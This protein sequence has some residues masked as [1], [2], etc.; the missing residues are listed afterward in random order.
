MMRER[1]FTLIEASITAVI[2]MVGVIALIQIG[3]ATTGQITDLRHTYGQPAIAERLIHDQAE[4]ILA[5]DTAPDPPPVVPPLGLG[6]IT[7]EVEA[8]RESGKDRGGLACYSIRVKFKGSYF[9]AGDP[10]SGPN[11]PAVYVWRP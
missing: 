8:A 4:A 7:Y 10:T 2:L 1:G 5:A 11:S 6:G 3:K 9:K